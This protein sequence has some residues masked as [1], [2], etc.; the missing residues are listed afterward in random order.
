MKTHSWIL[1]L[2]AAAALTPPGAF[3][4]GSYCACLP[5]PPPK[6]TTTAKVDREK[7]ALGQKTFN[8]KSAPVQGNVA[9]QTPR[10]QALQKQLPA[11]VAEKKDLTL[12]AGKISDEQLAALEYFV[13]E[14]Y[15]ASK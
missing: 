12:L 14:R 9:A 2:V 7:Y 4:S 6:G 3:A 13:T 15:P 1:S 5:K 11:K 8:G 10:L